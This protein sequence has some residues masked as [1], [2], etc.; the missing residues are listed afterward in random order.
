MNEFR[1]EGENI[2]INVPY[3]EA[4]IPLELFQD[5]KSSMSM[6]YGDGIITMGIF[7]MRFYKSEE[8]A[9]ENRDS[10]PLRTFSYPSSIFTLPSSY[11]DETLVLNGVEEKVKTL[12]YYQDDVMMEYHTVKNILNCE[13]Y[14]DALIKAKFPNS[15]K[16]EDL[17]INWHENFVQN[18]FHPGTLAVVLQIIIAENAR[19]KKDPSIPYRRYA[20]YAKEINPADYELVNMNTIAAN[21]SVFS[22]IGFERFKEKLSTS[23]TMSKTNAAQNIS[24][25]EKVILY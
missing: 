9:D 23:I 3:A 17:F 15:M 8:E 18:G 10:V 13:A 12:K 19:Y 24:P 4:Y 14:L 5:T 7:Y 16:Y 1:K 11:E 22:A 25:L 6:I 21:N 2:L 20:A